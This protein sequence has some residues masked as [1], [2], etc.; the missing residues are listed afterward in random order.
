MCLFFLHPQIGFQDPNR[1]SECI[2]LNYLVLFFCPL[3]G[4][5]FVL[6]WPLGN[7][8]E[9]LDLLGLAAKAL[10]TKPMFI[11]CFPERTHFL[12]TILKLKFCET[13]EDKDYKF[14]G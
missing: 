10:M 14:C 3:A 1:F 8:G 13:Q 4:T 9:E 5:S 2:P 12:E 11:I 6:V 7:P